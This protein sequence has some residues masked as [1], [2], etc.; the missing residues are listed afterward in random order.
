MWHVH[1]L[2][3]AD[4]DERD[5]PEPGAPRVTALNDRHTVIET[6]VSCFEDPSHLPLTGFVLAQLKLFRHLDRLIRTESISVIRVGDPYY[7]GLFGLALGRLNG[8]PVAVRINGNYDALYASMGQLAYPRLFR[9]RW[10]EKR[11]DRFVLPRVDL[12]AGSNEDNLNY[13]LDN[14]ARPERT[15]LFRYGNLIDPVH[16]TDPSTRPPPDRPWAGDGRRYLLC[17]SRLAAVKRPEAVVQVVAELHRRHPD[18]VAVFIGEGGMKPELERLADDLGIR[19]AI[20]F[21]GACDQATIARAAAH[22]AVIVSPMGGRALVET[23]LAAVPIVAY[24]FD[25]HAELIRHGE[26]GLLVPFGDTKAMADAVESLLVDR[27]AA[28]SLGRRSRLQTMEMMDTAKLVENERTAYERLLE[29]S[30][31]APVKAT[32]P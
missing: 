23:S 3:G 27:R 10:I 31:G 29:P 5:G 4:P 20:V 15:T 14:G 13:A 6:R 25:W 26:T 28:A 19:D 22:A 18:V 21:A 17:V 7:L 2:V 9:R 12:V 8:I 11:I 1:P 32:T 16:F 30:G 24:D